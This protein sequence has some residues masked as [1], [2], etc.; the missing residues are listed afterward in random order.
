MRRW[1]VDPSTV[2]LAWNQPQSAKTD[3]YSRFGAFERHFRPGGL[4][5]A[6]SNFVIGGS[7][8]S[9]DDTGGGAA[10]MSAWAQAGF[11]LG[12]MRTGSD[13]Q[14]A[15][16]LGE[17]MAFGVFIIAAPE[18]SGAAVAAQ[19]SNVSRVIKRFGCSPNLGGYVLGSSSAKLLDVAAATL[20]KK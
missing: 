4:A 18:Q 15:R 17:A 7:Y 14:M 6:E 10:S 3:M 11:V 19:P 2:N 1:F 13:K 12:S 9:W 5:G 16:A 8:D 20:P